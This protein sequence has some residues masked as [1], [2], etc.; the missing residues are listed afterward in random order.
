MNHSQNEKIRLEHEAAKLFMH[1][2]EKDTGV[3]FRHIWHNE[4]S[5]PDVSAWLDGERLD[6]EIAHLYGSEQEAMKI[7]GRDLSD[8]TL[9]ELRQLQ[10][11]QDVQKRLLFAL[12]RILNNKA[13][14]HYHTSRVWLVIRNAHPAWTKAHIEALQHRIAVPETHPFEQIWMVGDWQGKTGNLQLFP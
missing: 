5:Q 14:K 8:K 6:I 10:N 11:E 9:G 12:N 4:P 13:S 2:Y 1:R 7:L 3:H